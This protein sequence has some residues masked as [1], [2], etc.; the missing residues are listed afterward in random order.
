MSTAG[1]DAPPL[2]VVISGPSGVGKDAVIAQMRDSQPG[3][4]FAVTA[5]TRPMRAGEVDG[6]D[7][8]FLSSKRF[9]AMLDADGFLE[10]AEVYGNRYGVPREQVRA[11][12]DAGRD[13]IVKIDV[14]GAATIRRIAPD[15]LLIFLAAPSAGELERRLRARKTDSPEQ[16]AVRI[17]TAQHETQQA[18]WF[19][20]TIVNETGA[21]G[22]TVARI[23]EAIEEQRRR[24][25]A[26]RV[27]V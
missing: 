9:E 22:Q 15:A 21:V 8:V 7:Y 3:F 24:V 25:P 16:L 18:G 14:Q 13:I 6:R 17:E 12:L 23:I 4:A 11:A 19:D 1:A 20:V 26:R 10:H 27:V 2:L 5:T